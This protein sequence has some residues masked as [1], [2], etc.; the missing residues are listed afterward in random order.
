MLFG[1]LGLYFPLVTGDLNKTKRIAQIDLFPL[2][3]LFLQYLKSRTHFLFLTAPKLR[4][5]HTRVLFKNR[6]KSSFRIEAGIKGK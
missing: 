4:R 1:S 5:R 3:C 6:I 2:D